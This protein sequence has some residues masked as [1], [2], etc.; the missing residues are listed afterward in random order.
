LAGLLGFESAVKAIADVK[1]FC[2]S[3]PQMEKVTQTQNDNDKKTQTLPE[4]LWFS[5]FV[6]SET[7]C[8]RIKSFR[9]YK[10]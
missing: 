4:G 9:T 7:F 2:R 6:C 1:L 5:L 3:I 8:A 10:K